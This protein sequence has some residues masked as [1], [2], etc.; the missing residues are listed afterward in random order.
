MQENDT[1]HTDP[2][3]AAVSDTT[4]RPET[5]DETSEKNYKPI[6]PY[7]NT[8]Y[9][10]Y[11][12][13]DNTRYVR[14]YNHIPPETIAMES[15]NV[16]R[17]YRCAAAEPVKVGG[18][19]CVPPQHPQHTISIE[20]PSPKKLPSPDTADTAELTDNDDAAPDNGLGDDRTEYAEADT[21]LASS[22]DEND[23]LRK[24]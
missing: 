3:D 24:E 21:D 1:L 19:G 9:E 20:K 8:S 10:D 23:T 6:L 16:V 17:Y 12:M 14:D 18:E 13:Y 15:G 7:E 22:F 2:T 4:D 11:S 5:N